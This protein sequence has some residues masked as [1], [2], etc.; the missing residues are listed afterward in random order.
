MAWV[1]TNCGLSLPFDPIAPV[2]CSCGQA[3]Q[4]K[5]GTELKCIIPDLFASAGCD[6]KSYAAMMDRWGADECERR[7]DEIVEHLVQ[8]ADKIRLLP[9]INPL[10][11]FV[12]RRW[13]RQAI[14]RAR[15]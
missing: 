14:E 5:P 4:G 2:H 6:C 12:A 8:Q 3:K 10:N 7:F 1:C 15:R 9:K 13:V 11:R